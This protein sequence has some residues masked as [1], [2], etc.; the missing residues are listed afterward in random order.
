M[1]D[2]LPKNIPRILINRTVAHPPEQID[3]DGDEGNSDDEDSEF[4]EDYVFDAYLLGYCDDVTRALG[5]K[6]FAASDNAAPDPA[7]AD[8]RDE[9]ELLSVV[10][11]A[12]ESAYTAADWTA[13]GIPTD[14]VFLFPGAEAPTGMSEEVLYREIAH[15]DGCS[16]R[17]EGAIQKCVVCFDYD[18]CENC[19]PILAK[20]HY[21]GKHHFAE[22]AVPASNQL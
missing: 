7:N 2:Y 18:L 11:E 9:G 19:F 14:R 10:L 22:E 1:I 4:R 3:G 16:K 17:I 13:V 21:D 6:L 12:T 20:T 8:D 15:C 5:K